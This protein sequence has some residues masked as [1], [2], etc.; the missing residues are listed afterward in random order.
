[1]RVLNTC[2]KD[3]AGGEKLN[4][5]K[6]RAKSV[7]ESNAKLKVTFFWPFWAHYWIIDLDENYNYTVVSGLSRKY[8]D[9]VQG[10]QNGERNL[11]VNNEKS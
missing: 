7:S 5:A 8:M 3:F 1:M 6:G 10:T 2:W 4:N 11:R 9:T